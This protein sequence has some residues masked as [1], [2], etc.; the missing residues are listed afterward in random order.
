MLYALIIAGGRGMRFWPQSRRHRP[1]QCISVVGENSLIRQTVDRLDPLIPPERTLV[2]TGPDMVEA[3]RD[4]LPMLP[5]ENILVE[6]TGRNTAPCIGLGAIEIQKR[7]GNE[8]VMVVLPADHVITRPDVLR[9]ALSAASLAA[10]ETK[11]LVTL[12]ICP[13]HAETG[14]GYLQKS[15]EVGTWGE[16]QLHRVSKFTEKPNAKVA[17]E[18]LHGG[19]H[20]WNAGMFVFTVEAILNAFQAH[21]PRSFEALQK[22]QKA[23]NNLNECWENMEATSIDFGIMERAEKILTV[24]VDPGWSDVGTWGAIAEFLPE[25]EGG[26]GLANHVISIDSE[27]CTIHAQ[28]QVV[29][30]LGVEDLVIVRTDDAI[31]VAKQDR[32]Q[33]VRKIVSRLSEMG[34]SQYT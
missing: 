14:Y 22:I 28:G 3:I 24:P 1:K 7:A 12:G 25:V 13:T 8:A 11:A 9:G 26:K 23:P 15:E 17:H 5:T 32:V 21:L 6:P 18:Y 34:L 2:I 10:T 27:G 4:Q 19:Q 31:L 33:D 29:A 30:L 20:L 16:F